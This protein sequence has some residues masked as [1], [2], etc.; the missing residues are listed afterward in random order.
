[1]PSMSVSTPTGAIG[2]HTDPSG[3][4]PEYSASAITAWGCTG[5]PANT[6]PSPTVASSGTASDT[7]MSVGRFSTT[8]SAPSAPCSITSTTARR[9]LGSTSVGVAIRSW[10][11]SDSADTPAVYGPVQK[12]LAASGGCK[13]SPV[14]D[15]LGSRSL[16][17]PARLRLAG[18]V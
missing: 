15:L 9:K 13:P 14:R 12:V 4:G 6:Q 18:Y 16:P 7:A 1:S 5:P 8:P 2:P 3:G 10:P 17:N 11:L